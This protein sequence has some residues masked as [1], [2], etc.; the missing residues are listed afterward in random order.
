[1]QVYLSSPEFDA[2]SDYDRV[3]SRA[4]ELLH[5][6]KGLAIL[7]LNFRPDVEF[8]HILEIGD[9]SKTTHYHSHAMDPFISYDEVEL[10]ITDVS[11]CGKRTVES[12][13]LLIESWTHLSC[14][15]EKVAKTLRMLGSRELNWDNLYKVLEII[16]SD[17]GSRITV[18][19][20]ASDSKL[21][22]FTRTANSSR[23]IGD[24]ARHGHVRYE[25][26]PIPM[27]LPEARTII[28]SIVV[29]WLDSKTE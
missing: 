28:T 27:M 3:S 15:D 12:A 4:T 20:W 11:S 14:T 8:D 7:R 19:G 25:P 22:Q 24:D 21:D 10:E 5:I 16:Q 9:A 6:M 13:P 1:M 23:A 18:E 26:P 17:V 29:R 2:L